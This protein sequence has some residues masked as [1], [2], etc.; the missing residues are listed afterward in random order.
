[1]SVGTPVDVEFC[2]MPSAMDDPT[3][4]PNGSGSN[5]PS[6]KPSCK[7]GCV[8]TYAPPPKKDVYMNPFD[9]KELKKH[10]FYR[11][12]FAELIATMIFV[13]SSIM[14]IL[15]VEDL[16][17]D[18]CRGHFALFVVGYHFV[19]ILLII[20]AFSALS[21]AHF[22][23]T[24]SFTLML[25]RRITILRGGCYIVVQFVGAIIGAGMAK[26][27]LPSDMEG[28]LTVAAP[29]G[30]AENW[31]ALLTEIVISFFFIF[32][33]FSLAFDPRG[34]GKLAPIGIAA[35]VA[36]NIYAGFAVSGGGMNPAR[37][38]GPAVIQWEWDHFWVYLVGPIVGGS[39]AGLIYEHLFM[40]RD[41][42]KPVGV[43]STA[44]D[45]HPKLKQHEQ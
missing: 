42:S 26:A 22:N 32:A 8:R 43:P 34:F 29:K 1:M 17:L 3:S 28:N 27:C 4:S 9:L 12:V 6:R 35:A 44:G 21:G 41:Q 37:A 20:F 11:G 25:V 7:I 23:P 2:E 16:Y 31:E 33:L 38:F 39:I 5:H 10:D 24:V 13:Y 18:C 19:L 36:L 15:T 45:N 30:D 40:Y 14:I